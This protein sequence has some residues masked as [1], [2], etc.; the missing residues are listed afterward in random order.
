MNLNLVLAFLWLL[1]GGGLVVWHWLN[2]EDL[3]LRFWGSLSVGWAFLVLALYNVA[4]WWSAQSY[5]KERRLAQEATRRREQELAREAPLA[6]PEP[7]P[8]FDFNRMP[9]T[10]RPEPPR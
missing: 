6:N 1:L 5:L 3:R 4:R 8:N 10:E 2:P 7:D 9:P